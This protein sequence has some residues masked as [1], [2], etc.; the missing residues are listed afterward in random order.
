[1]VFQVY[2]DVPLRTMRVSKRRFLPKR[3]AARFHV[4]WMRHEE[5]AW[6]PQ[7]RRYVFKLRGGLDLC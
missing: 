1:M 2:V 6:N 7:C 4:R 3:S 5:T